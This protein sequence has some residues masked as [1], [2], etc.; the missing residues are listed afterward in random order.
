MAHLRATSAH[1]DKISAALRDGAGSIPTTWEGARDHCDAM[2]G[3][4]M[5]PYQLDLLT[6][7]VC[8]RAA[9]KAVLVQH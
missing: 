1:A 5:T 3:G 7:M 8:R 2:T 9:I 6:D 4:E